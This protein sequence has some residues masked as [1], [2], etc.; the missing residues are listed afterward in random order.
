MIPLNQT[1]QVNF[2]KGCAFVSYARKNEAALAIERLNGV[3]LDGK[4]LRVTWSRSSGMFFTMMPNILFTVYKVQ[5]LLQQQRTLVPL[6]QPESH[7]STPE[8]NGT[9]S[10]SPNS[11]RSPVTPLTPFGQLSLPNVTSQNGQRQNLRGN[12]SKSGSAINGGLL[13]NLYTLR[14]VDEAFSPKYGSHHNGFEMNA[15]NMA[16]RQTIANIARSRSNN[17]FDSD[18]MA[19]NMNGRD[20]TSSDRLGVSVPI[21]RRVSL[22]E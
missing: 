8:T 19:N 22:P 15:P 18:S 5:P 14:E 2:G 3:V 9:A 10:H 11:P 4:P 21:A 17:L 13:P 20:V 1:M 12:H 7:E 6:G 16:R